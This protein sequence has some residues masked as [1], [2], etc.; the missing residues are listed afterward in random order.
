MQQPSDWMRL[1]HVNVY[2][3]SK[4]IGGITTIFLEIALIGLL[5][6]F[7]YPIS[8]LGSGKCHYYIK[9]KMYVTPRFYIPD[10]C[11]HVLVI[12]SI[13]FFLHYVLC[14]QHLMLD[15]ASAPALL[16]QTDHSMA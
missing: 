4:L 12:K 13:L 1:V 11:Y 16:F 5:Q 14:E 6:L 15:P 2:A 8:P 9:L 10:T 3:N 7:Y